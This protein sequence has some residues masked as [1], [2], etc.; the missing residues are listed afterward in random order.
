MNFLCLVLVSTLHDLVPSEVAVSGYFTLGWMY[1]GL[2]TYGSCFSRNTSF[3]IYSLAGWTLAFIMQMQKCAIVFILT[4]ASPI[5]LLSS[6]LSTTF[7]LKSSDMN[8]RSHSTFH[9]IPLKA[10]SIFPLV[11]LPCRVIKGIYE[12]PNSYKC[13]C[14]NPQ[15]NHEHELGVTGVWD[16]F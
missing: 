13:M 9:Q 4:Y 11:A 12:P 8:V 2:R 14:K 1:G 3:S 10:I 6:G 15:M 7:T 5:I 16:W